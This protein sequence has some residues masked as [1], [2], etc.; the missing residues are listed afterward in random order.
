[1]R[2]WTTK[3]DVVADMPHDACATI[4]ARA[5]LCGRVCSVVMAVLL[6]GERYRFDDLCPT[7]FAR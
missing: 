6:L 7:V 1:M 3:R 2:Q 4:A 5:L